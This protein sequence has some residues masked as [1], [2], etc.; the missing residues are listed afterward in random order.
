MKEYRRE[1]IC[2]VIIIAI[3][4][5]LLS[6]AALAAVLAI[7]LLIPAAMRQFLL[8]G[9]S[10]LSLRAEIKNSC[11]T[12]EDIGL[13][14]YT[15]RKRGFMFPGALLTEAE[16]KNDLLG[17]NDVKSFYIPLGRKAGKTVLPYTSKF[18]GKIKISFKSTKLC[19]PLGL[20]SVDIKPPKDLGIIIYPQKI[21]LNTLKNKT[22]QSYISG[23]HSDGAEKG[24]DNTEVFDLRNYQSGDPM[25]SVHWKLSAKLDRELIIKESSNP[26]N[27]D[28]LLYIETG[29]YYRK[30]RLENKQ[31][32]AV[33]ETGISLGESI[34]LMNVAYHL[35][36]PS[37]KGIYKISIS[38]MNSFLNSIDEL[39]S[40]KAPQN[41]LDWLEHIYRS[42]M[43]EEYGRLICVVWNECPSILERISEFIEVIVVIVYDHKRK[44]EA[45][46]YNKMHIAALPDNEIYE[47]SFIINI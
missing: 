38:D 44:M 41:R 40:I 13:V 42:G 1:Y 35:A 30:K 17:I 14:L 8:I 46:D 3:L 43:I 47:K 10:E 7:M 22:P 20:F 4:T 19:G 32:S 21:D 26:F 31:I 39:M 28:T 16:F 11:K 18:C 36:V 23:E 27:Y 34:T 9:I 2:G 12:E 15:D 45:A 6:S 37:D 25:H 24:S 29:L 5:F 33:I